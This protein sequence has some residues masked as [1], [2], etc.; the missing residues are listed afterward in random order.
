MDHVQV[1]GVDFPESFL[2]IGNHDFGEAS[3]RPEP[4]KAL[5]FG[6]E[7]QWESSDG[8]IPDLS[9]SDNSTPLNST[10]STLLSIETGSID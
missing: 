6:T 7:R 1:L 8:T 4:P 2:D 9:V 5:D 3:H 10:F